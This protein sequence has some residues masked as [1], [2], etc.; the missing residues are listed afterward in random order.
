[1][2]TK[3]QR[4]Y[5]RWKRRG[6]TAQRGYGRVHQKLR[7]SWKPYVDAGMA[8]CHA[9]ECLEERDGHGRWITPGT[10]WHLGHTAD[11]TAWTGPEHARCNQAE[12][13][14][15]IAGGQPV[16]RSRIW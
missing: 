6:T 2:L 10:P 12:R 11:R 7:A 16:R 15:R 1:M 4:D 9:A 5:Q 14:V 13:N 3:Q 8:E